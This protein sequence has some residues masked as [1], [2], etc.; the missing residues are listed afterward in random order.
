MLRDIGKYESLVM[1]THFTVMLV[2]LKLA[3][4]AGFLVCVAALVG[5]K[6]RHTWS[7]K[8]RVH[9]LALWL[10]AALI[11]KALLLVFVLA[12]ELLTGHPQPQN[13][14]E[15]VLNFGLTLFL[16]KSTDYK[17]F[18]RHAMLLFLY[19]GLMSRDV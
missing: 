11:A 15:A 8:V 10:A 17:L 16:L 6:H 9:R 19:F 3:F 13:L 18:H 4:H 5:L 1:F 7:K 2:S 14:A 12:R